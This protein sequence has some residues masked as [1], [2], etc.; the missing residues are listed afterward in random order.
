[1]YSQLSQREGREET[2]VRELTMQWAGGQPFCRRGDWVTY[3]AQLRDGATQSPFL[4]IGH[5]LCKGKGAI[6]GALHAQD[7]RPSATP[8]PSAAFLNP[9]DPVWAGKL[10]GKTRFES[11]PQS[12]HPSQLS[13]QLLLPLSG[14]LATESARRKYFSWHLP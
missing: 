10:R 13:P 6:R 2:E 14:C 9:Q 12:S 11:G 1:M 7:S 4:A 5:S 8:P 3:Q